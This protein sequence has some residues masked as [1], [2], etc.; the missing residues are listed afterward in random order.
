MAKLPFRVPHTLILLAGMIVL[1]YGLT[2]ILPQG[3]F[4]RVKNDKGREQV[5]AGSFKTIEGEDR[6]GWTALFTS[7]PKG[8]EAAGEI[9]F[10]IFIIGG[11]F[12]VFRA[13]GAAD[14][15]IG[16]MLKSL[17]GRPGLLIAGGMLVFA[18]GSATIGMAEEYLLFVTLLVALGAALGMDAV[19]AVGIL[20]VGY[21][22]GYAAAI[23][24]PFTVVVAQSI[25]GI[26]QGSGMGFRLVLLAAFFVLGFHHVWSYYQKVKKD[27]SKSLVADVPPIAKVGEAGYPALTGRHVVVLVSLGLTLAVLI[28]G[29]IAY[30][31]YLIE[32]GALFLGLTVV[33]AIAGGLG[34]DHSAR[35]F[36]TGA[37]ELTTTALLVG[38][39]RAIQVVLDEGRVIDTIIHGV[40]QPLQTLGPHLAAIGMFVVQGVVNFFIPSGSGQAYVTMPLMAPL[41]DLVG[42]SRQV[43]VIAYQ[44]GDGI[45]N[46]L[47]P[48]NAV[49][50][51]I[52]A[53]AGVPFDRWLRYIVP[54]VIKASLLGAVAL[55]VA[56]SLGIE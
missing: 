26:P 46:I 4:D 19:T 17:S 35:E 15:A 34:A 13:T 2:L 9:I 37:A 49:L 12:G 24:N 30:E 6:L 42:V 10:F 40:A 50:V 22:L 31:W 28:W 47:W 53:M 1:A 51:G 23:T 41:A 45:N 14:A 32:M 52:L 16:S 29:L 27:P 3:S 11:M 5:V 7:V 21:G 39:S 43:S 38:F 20:C 44:L 25:A 56:V 36:C 54:F 48:T 18:A 55:V 33:L 8:F